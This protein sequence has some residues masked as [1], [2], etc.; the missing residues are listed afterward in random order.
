MCSAQ[1]R[2]QPPSNDA[3]DALLAIGERGI[4]FKCLAE[5]NGRSAPVLLL[6]VVICQAVGSHAH[7]CTDP[8]R[9]M[10][11]SSSL[12]E[13]FSQSTPGLSTK[14]SPLIFFNSMSHTNRNPPHVPNTNNHLCLLRSV[15][16]T[17]H[18]IHTFFL[19]L[20][21][22]VAVTPV[23]RS[24]SSSLTMRVPSLTHTAML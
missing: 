7:K 9:Y 10:M 5:G 18:I 19:Q 16:T 22:S 15:F 12:S 8:R 14:S 4:Q 2:G 1:A 20:S 6:H 21:L 13:V 24:L 17:L 11:P 23:R 3:V